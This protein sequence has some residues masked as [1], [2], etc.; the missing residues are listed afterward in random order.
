MSTNIDDNNIDD[1]KKITD[2][3]NIGG[4]ANKKEAKLAT[5]RAQI[6]GRRETSEPGLA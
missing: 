6:G 1:K 4:G 5:L 2:N 3:S